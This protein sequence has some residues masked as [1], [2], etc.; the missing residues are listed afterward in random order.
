MQVSCFLL[1]SR[2]SVLLMASMNGIC[3]SLYVFARSFS[4]AITLPSLIWSTVQSS[5]ANALLKISLGSVE[6][7]EVQY[8]FQVFPLIQR[9]I[10]CPLSFWRRHILTH[11]PSKYQYKR[12][13]RTETV[14]TANIDAY[15]LPPLCGSL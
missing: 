13:M 7:T 14:K 10:C 5:S 9:T 6:P 2:Y 11:R 4:E 1:V 8:C 3:T 15:I 12:P